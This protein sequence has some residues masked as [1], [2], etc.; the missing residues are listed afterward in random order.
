MF[1]E[2]GIE[3]PWYYGLIDYRF[4]LSGTDG[5]EM[6]SEYFVPYINAIPAIKEVH[7]PFTYYTYATFNSEEIVQ[8]VI[9]S[10]SGFSIAMPK[11][12][13]SFKKHENANLKSIS[14]KFQQSINY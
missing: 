2:Q 8:S 6:H 5:N 7:I 12:D 13:R 11:N 4:G 9:L 10:Y 3:Q 14:S 1:R